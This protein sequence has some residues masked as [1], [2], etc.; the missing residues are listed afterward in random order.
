MNLG[1]I[2]SNALKRLIDIL[3]LTQE[4]PH[5]FLG[6]NENI[7]LPHVFGGQIIAQS[8]MA[9]MNVVEPQRQLHACY[10]TFLQAG[11][12]D[13]PLYFQTEILRE[14]NSFSVVNVN[15][16]QKEQRICQVT[17]SFQL[18]ENGLEHHISIPSAPLPHKLNNEAHHIQ[19]M[20]EYLP[21]PLKEL[22]QT[23]RAFDV[24][25]THLNNPFK[26]KKLPAEQLL[27]AKLNGEIADAPLSQRLQQCLIAY[28]S[29]FHCIQTMLHPHKVGIMQEGLKIATLNHNIYFHRDINFSDWLLFAL[30]NTNAY[31]ARGLTHGEVFS[32]DGA[33]LMS[34]QQEALIR[35]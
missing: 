8:M 27:W 10:S 20:A 16:I 34:Y 26:G 23:E 22:L 17:T 21:S 13:S 35:L 31:G 11:E 15:V 3:T 29:D 25:I 24:Q 5:L 30:R 6:K 12:L 7:G 18:P 33:L 9:A 32:K 1:E 28:F 19:K 2:M 4:S 14:G